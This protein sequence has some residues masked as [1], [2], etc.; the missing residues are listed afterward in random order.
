MFEVKISG[1][2]REPLTSRYIMMLEPVDDTG[3]DVVIPVGKFE[4]ENIHSRRC[5]GGNC[6]KSPFDILSPILNWTDSVTFEKLVIDNCDCGIFTAKLYI[7]V[8]GT[9]RIIDCRPSD[10]VVLAIDRKLPVFVSKVLTCP[11]VD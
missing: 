8:G 11:E 10:G 5:T 7:S 3:S 1:V 9:Q 4:A 6:K 2:I